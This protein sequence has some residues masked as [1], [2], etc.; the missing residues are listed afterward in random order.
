MGQKVSLHGVKYAGMPLYAWRV[1]LIAS[2]LAQPAPISE[3]RRCTRNSVRAKSGQGSGYLRSFCQNARSRQFR[4][5]STVHAYSNHCHSYLRRGV[6]AAAV[7]RISF[8]LGDFGSVE[9]LAERQSGCSHDVPQILTCWP[10]QYVCIKHW[11]R[12]KPTNNYSWRG[13]LR[14]TTSSTRNQSTSATLNSSRVS[15]TY[16]LTDSRAAA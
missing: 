6:A 16:P 10:P 12:R 5:R 4:A 8:T 15:R 2:V 7:D 3:L 1:I 14:T 9:S 11:Q 13:T